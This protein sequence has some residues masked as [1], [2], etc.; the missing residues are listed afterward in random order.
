MSL[1]ALLKKLINPF[2]KI[3]LLDRMIFRGMSFLED[4]EA[5][6]L[7]EEYQNK[8]AS[9]NFTNSKGYNISLIKDLRSSIK[10][11]WENMLKPEPQ[12]I[13]LQSVNDLTNSLK[14]SKNQIKR[15]ISFLGKYSID[16][17]NKNI[18][19]IGTY[20]GVTA[21]AIAENV[22]SVIGSDIAA[23]YINQTVDGK[24]SSE[25]IDRKNKELMKKRSAYSDFVGREISKKVSFIED[26]ITSSSIPSESIDFL[27][28][29]E[30]LEHI[31][32]PEK[33]F[34]EMYRILK[35]GGICIS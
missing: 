8:N 17:K 5:Y 21:F 24:L 9:G 1:K 14:S 18:L 3:P 13:I 33:A 26:D 16:I 19:E 2:V 29:Y 20:D 22:N 23:Y 32:K 25:S 7:S 35:P 34:S 27:F 10:P 28:S 31:T 30:V 4:Y 12:T 11:G 6:F 15:M